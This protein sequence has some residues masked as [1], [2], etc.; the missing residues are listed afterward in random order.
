MMMAE[1]NPVQRALT[2]QLA[3]P[4]F[5]EFCSELVDIF[6]EIR[7]DTS[8]SL[9]SYIPEL[10]KRNPDDFAFAVCTVDGQQFEYGTSEKQFPLEGCV[11]PFLYLSCLEQYGVEQ[12]HKRVGREP[13][14]APFDAVRVNANNKPHNAMVNTGALALTSMMHSE[15]DTA[16]R[17]GNIVEFLQN[18]GGGKVEPVPY[19]LR[20]LAAALFA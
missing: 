18:V 19:V 13:S 1:D 11:T 8:G 15:M 9:C 20:A 14:G 16:D 3:V 7:P 12:V 4:N 10:H 2:G 5:V 17:F 6:N